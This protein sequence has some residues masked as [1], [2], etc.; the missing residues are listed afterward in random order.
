MN[1]L[2]IEKDVNSN[3]RANSHQADFII[4][5]HDDFYDQALSLKS[6]RE[7]CD[8]LKTE[9]AKIS[10]V[11][12]E[13]SW[14]LFDPVAI[15]DFIKYTFENWAIQPRYVLLFGSGDFDYRNIIERYTFIRHL[16]FRL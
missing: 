16:N 4:I 1:P 5:T 9:V 11:Y 15:R 7:N 14:G 3:L 6:L 10:D 2:K 8:N 12:D 13:F